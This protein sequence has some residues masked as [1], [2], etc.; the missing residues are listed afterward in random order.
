MSAKY[1]YHPTNSEILLLMY[2]SNIK[3]QD[4]SIKKS[5]FPKDFSSK[6]LQTYMSLLTPKTKR[7]AEYILKFRNLQQVKLINSTIA[8]E[9]GCTIRTVIRATNKFN[10]DGFITKQQPHPYDANNFSFHEKTKKGSGAFS[11]WFNGLPPATQDTYISHGVIIDHKNK[12][13][14]SQRNVTPYLSSSLRDSLFKNSSLLL[15]RAR[16][17][18]QDFSKK[19]KGKMVKEENK[20]ASRMYPVWQPPKEEPLDYQIAAKELSI[21]GFRRQV[22]KPE[23]F[24][25]PRSILFE[26]NVNV[27]RSF[28]LRDE[29]ELEELKKKRAEIET[30]GSI[31][32]K[33]I[34]L[35][36]YYADSMEPYSS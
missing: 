12:K 26:V 17:K 1:K 20:M 18:R 19:I 15:V 9:V 21:L 4:F 13:I 10:E 24:W 6:D 14:V 16:E 29:K 30:E 7:V 31:D 23:E 28:L 5:S 25:D 35:H 32:E 36:Q 34:I 27:A 33:Q 8:R 11:Y 2:H 3:N 22:E